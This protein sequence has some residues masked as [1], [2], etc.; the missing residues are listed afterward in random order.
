MFNQIINEEVRVMME[1]VNLN[2][3]LNNKFKIIVKD[4]Y[5]QNFEYVFVNFEYRV[6]TNLIFCLYLLKYIDIL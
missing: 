3:F 6:I 5:F 2:Y 1:M 4:T